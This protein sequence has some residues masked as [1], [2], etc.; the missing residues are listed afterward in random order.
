MYA[1]P[2]TFRNVDAENGTCIE[3]TVISK[4]ILGL[5]CLIR[6]GDKW[7]LAETPPTEPVARVVLAPDT[8]WKLFSKSL[9]PDDVRDEILVSGDEKLAEVALGM[10]SVMA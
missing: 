9:R 8:A 3:I 7:T 1:L 5:W 4:D 10:I 6:S 2:H